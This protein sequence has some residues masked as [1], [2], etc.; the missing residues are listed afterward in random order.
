MISE[1]LQTNPLNG[2]MSTGCGMLLSISVTLDTS[3]LVKSCVLAAV[4]TA[5]SYAVTQ[6]MKR[7]FR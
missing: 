2:M 3:D 1:K 7:V 4:G 6:V 5:T